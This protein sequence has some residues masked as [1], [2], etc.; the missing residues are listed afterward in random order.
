M[1]PA[2]GAFSS[3]GLFAESSVKVGEQVTGAD[4][5]RGIEIRV[6]PVAAFETFK[7]G[8]DPVLGLSVSTEGAA[9]GGE[10]RT[11][12]LHLDALGCGLV[13]YELFQLPEGP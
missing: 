13:A 10:F 6:H 7:L 5:P 12:G 2:T 3:C 1:Q 4:I 9:L 11:D 8:A